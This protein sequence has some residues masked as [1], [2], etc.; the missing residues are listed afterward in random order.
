M[1]GFAKLIRNDP[2]G[3]PKLVHWL[4][5]ITMPT[6][7]LWGASDRLRPTA[8]AEARKAGLPDARV[9]LVP[10]TGHLVFEETP[11]AAHHVTD[12]LAE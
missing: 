2:Q 7:V 11:S 9:T 5:R 12:F 8:Q 1:T 6:L 3:N 4:H 10:D